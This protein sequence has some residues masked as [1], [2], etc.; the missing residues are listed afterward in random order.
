MALGA[1]AWAPHDRTAGTS[2]T[3]TQGDIQGSP[4]PCLTCTTTCL[5]LC[6]AHLA[7][8]LSSITCQSGQLQTLLHE[9]FLDFHSWKGSA[10]LGLPLMAL[11]ILTSLR[12]VPCLFELS[13]SLLS[14]VGEQCQGHIHLCIP[15]NIWHNNLHTI[16]AQQMSVKL[17]WKT[18]R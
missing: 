10:P 11:I 3:A 1:K 12:V 13:T 18:V 9:A 6:S 5:H 16:G 17:N 7:P 15:N 8:S 2:T 14:Q 4:G